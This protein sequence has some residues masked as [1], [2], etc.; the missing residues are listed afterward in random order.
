[1]SRPVATKLE[2]KKGI[3]HSKQKNGT[4]HQKLLP[5]SRSYDISLELY[6]C[7]FKTRGAVHNYFPP[8]A[9]TL[10]I[11]KKRVNIH[12]ALRSRI[13]S[14]EGLQLELVFPILQYTRNRNMITSE[15]TR[16]HARIVALE[17]KR[18]VPSAAIHVPP[19]YF[20][21]PVFRLGCEQAS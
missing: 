15:L 11:N 18:Q 20:A 7:S 8:P 12:I 2:K 3:R 1:M 19:T 13:A 4:K 21:N 6:T 10:K 9:H 17:A 14:L 16:E 5:Y